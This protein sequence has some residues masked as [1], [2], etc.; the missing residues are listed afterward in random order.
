MAWPRG[1]C[2][3]IRRRKRVELASH[4]TTCGY[5]LKVSKIETG[6]D[7]PLFQP[8]L[9]ASDMHVG[10]RQNDAIINKSETVTP[11]RICGEST[12]NVASPQCRYILGRIHNAATKCGH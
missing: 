1:G 7:C 4:Q 3:N 5:G 2:T 10:V 9:A 11:H 8:V 12:N 6:Y